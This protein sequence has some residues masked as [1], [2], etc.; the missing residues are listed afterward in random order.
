M[1]ISNSS[2]S[3]T[4]ISLLTKCK[5][6]SKYLILNDVMKYRLSKLIHSLL[7]CT[8]GLPEV[9]HKLIIPTDR[10]YTRNARKKH[11]VYSIREKKPRASTQMRAI[12]NME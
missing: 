5:K 7:K 10:I 3:K 12:T 2:N 8:P 4:G 1:L 6:N 11:Q 9:L